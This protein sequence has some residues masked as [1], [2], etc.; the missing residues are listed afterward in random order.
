MRWPLATGE[1]LREELLAAWGSADRGYHDLRHLTEVLDRLADLGCDDVRVLLA[2][3]FHDSVY[4]GLPSAEERSAA[5][6]ERA[7]GS[8]G[9]E[10]GDVAEVARLVRLTDHHRPEPGDVAG[11]FLCDADLAILAAE[12]SRY[13][14]YVVGVRREYSHVSDAD[15]AAGRASALEGLLAKPT[16]FG[17]AY[18]QARWEAPARANLARELARLR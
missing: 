12:H 2:A 18:A 1:R 16:L 11:V 14:E 6:A 7:L 15:F 13:E 10:P 3:W 17:T 9:V 4:D 8:L 5:W